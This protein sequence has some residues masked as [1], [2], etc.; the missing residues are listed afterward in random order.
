MEQG[1]QGRDAAP[2]PTDGAGKPANGVGFK[3]NQ[4]GRE[5]TTT[6]VLPPQVDA[7]TRRRTGLMI[8]LAVVAL[9]ALVVVSIVR[10]GVDRRTGGQPRAA[11]FG[12]QQRPIEPGAP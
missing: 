9:A 4:V 12:P 5:E 6:R 10:L 2:E 11:D 8:A 3:F 1:K 7:A